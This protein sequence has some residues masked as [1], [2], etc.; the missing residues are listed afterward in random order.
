VRATKSRVDFAGA[1]SV[2]DGVTTVDGLRAPVSIRRDAFGVAHVRAQNDHDAFFGQGFAAAQDR[3][4][5]MEYDRRRAAGRWAEA[6]G[7]NAVAGDTLARKLQLTR[8]AKADVKAMSPATRAVFDAY[9]AGVN[10]FLNSGQ[11]LPVEFAL[12]GLNPEPWQVWH[13][14]AAFK[15]RHVL[16]GVWQ[17]KLAQ[18]R[19]LAMIGPEAYAKLD[20]QPPIGSA[21]IVPPS[22]KVARLFKLANAEIAAAAQQLGFL[23]EVEA[24][25]NSWAVHG[26]R[27]TTGMPVLCNDS[28]R[29]LD[30]PSVY[31]QV[32]VA[33]PEFDAIGATFPGLPGFPHFGHN[34]RVAWNITHTSADYQ[35]LYVEQ[36]D[37]KNPTRYRTPDG[38]A[39]AE[40][41]NETIQVRGRDPVTIETWRTRHGPVVHGDPRKGV[42]IAL[43]YTA[44][45]A[46]TKAFESLRPMLAAGSVEELFESQRDWVDPVNNL[47]A[48]DTSGNIGYLTR[49]Y[50]PIRSSEAHREF[51][52]AGWTGKNEWTGRVPFEQLPRTI[53]PDEGIVATANQKVVPG[54]EP[55]ISHK[56]AVPSRAERIHELLAA[57]PK[58]R[59]EE[60]AAIQGDTTSRPAL[61]WGRLLN[62]SG[63]Y[64]GAAER[65]RALLAGWDGNLLPDSAQALLYAYF[66]R[67]I[68]R[69]LYEPVVGKRAW[70]W[71]TSEEVPSLGRMITQ[72]LANVIRAL[73]EDQHPSIL[74]DRR[75]NDVLPAAL[76]TAWASTV[77]KAGSDPAKWRWADHHST[78]AQHTLA[79][80]FPELA[81]A[82]NP[83]PVAVG[84]DS[85][86]VQC[87]GYGW[88]GRKDFDVSSLS[89]YRQVVDFADVAKTTFVIPG[90][91][92]GMPGTEHYNDQL[93]HWRAHR[94]ISAHYTEV[95]VESA[96]VHRL[97]LTPA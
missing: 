92:W 62:R 18:A 94:R 89:V 60:I 35:D 57:T 37:P 72:W 14:V 29:A 20:G 52:A 46:P 6:A 95:D 90:G 97:T 47:V 69:G 15:I 25:S 84:G 34:G 75:W 77:R 22:G 45:D 16:M 43:R 12:A 80:T 87:S 66:R 1:V 82:I 44:T 59:P 7:K 58:H 64:Q 27:T 56:F 63:P 50:L 51:P 54:E 42:A 85:D 24:G 31:W 96:A 71:M 4:W 81:P 55:Y 3:L 10:A 86:T 67:E 11:P 17:Q 2:L 23:A 30:V 93:E 19:L 13:S 48:A 88:S 32:H 68:T 70:A 79:V 74:G 76:G 8:A 26:S 41:M 36:F 53:N 28:H 61:T 49:G 40:H 39:S 21:V 83:T 9:A 5:Q 78:N 38:W 33:C 73:D 91:V 65:A